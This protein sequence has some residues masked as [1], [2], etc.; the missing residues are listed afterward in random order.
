MEFKEFNKQVVQ[1][2][3][4]FLG[5]GAI[6]SVRDIYKNNGILLHGLTIM[7]GQS[8]LWPTIYLDD[9]YQEHLK[10]T[11]LGSIIKEILHI[12]ENSRVKGKVSM[13]FFR[14]YEQT[15]RK[16]FCKIINYEKNVE[17][18]REVPFRRYEDLAVV[19]YYAYVSELVG[20]GSITIRREHLETWQIDEKQ[21][22]QEAMENTRRELPYQWY[23]MNAMVRELCKEE[24]CEE[25]DIEECAD[26]LWEEIFPGKKASPMYVVTNHNKYFGA[27]CMIYE[28]MLEEMGERIGSD[29]V[30]LPSSIHEVILVAAGHMSAEKLRAM[31]REVNELHVDPQEVLSDNVYYYNRSLRRLSLL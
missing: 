11:A 6:V 28:D 22:F 30:I 25:E 15:R 12:Y 23:N 31:V 21:L 17:M 8:N 7:D 18:L 1:A 13:D 9:L 5:K 4:Q 24:T 2:L 29:Y 26:L 3:E 14:D 10:G 16:I 27:I 19:C 20:N